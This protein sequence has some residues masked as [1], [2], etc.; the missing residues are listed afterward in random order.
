MVLNWSGGKTFHKD[1]FRSRLL[2]GD[3]LQTLEVVLEKRREFY[4]KKDFV[5]RWHL[6]SG[7]DLIEVMR[8]F[9]AGAEKTPVHTDTVFRASFE[10]VPENITVVEE[11]LQGELRR[12]VD[13]E[14][15]PQW[16]SSQV[17]FGGDRGVQDGIFPEG[18]G[19]VAVTRRREGVKEEADHQPPK[20]A[21]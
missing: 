5:K 19:V 14:G 15:F 7:D 12:V 16:K 4:R 2:N 13:L 1:G 6:R 10:N 11:K 18:N 17:Y 3:E 8:A 20:Q 9:V 21:G